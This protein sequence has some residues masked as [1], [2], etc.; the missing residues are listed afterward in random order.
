MINRH[1]IKAALAEWIKYVDTLTPEEADILIKPIKDYLDNYPALVWQ[2][3]DRY[4][5]NLPTP[6]PDQLLIIASRRKQGRAIVFHCISY[7]NGNEWEDCQ[8][9]SPQD[10]FDDCN[11][12]VVEFKVIQI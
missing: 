5:D 8:H 7:A 6:N 1:N 11:M 12:E 3:T 2:P 10:A 4:L 9:R